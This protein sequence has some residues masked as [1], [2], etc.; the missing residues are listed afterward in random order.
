MMVTLR[1]ERTSPF[2]GRTHVREMEVDLDK[3]R[4]WGLNL[5]GANQAFPHLSPGDREFLI[6]GITEEE[7]AA[8]MSAPGTPTSDSP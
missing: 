6:T 8:G 2:T 3:F 7:W 1:V 5:V 4:M